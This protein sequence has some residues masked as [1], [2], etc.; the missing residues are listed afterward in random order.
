MVTW[1]LDGM[2]LLVGMVGGDIPCSFV[3]E[4]RSKI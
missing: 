3:L 1:W 4:S 2:V